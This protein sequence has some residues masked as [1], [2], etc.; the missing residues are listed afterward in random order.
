MK[1]HY[2]CNTWTISMLKWHHIALP[3]IRWLC[4]NNF[5][6]EK[7]T[8]RRLFN[9]E[10]WHVFVKIYGFWF[11][12]KG[13]R[14]TRMST[15]TL[16]RQH[17]HQHYSTSDFHPRRSKQFPKWKSTIQQWW[18]LDSPSCSDSHRIQLYAINWI[19][20]SITKW[21]VCCAC[22]PQPLWCILVYH[23]TTLCFTILCLGTLWGLLLE[24][25]QKNHF[26]FHDVNGD[27]KFIWTIGN[28]RDKKEFRIDSLLRER[29][30][31]A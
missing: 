1:N 25:W 28:E 21:I 8:L 17:K 18:W 30:P 20:L 13:L 29:L 10:M 31:K 9:H 23:Q 6:N 15:V 12:I 11:A 2:A 19:K 16:C 22:T 5:G 7:Q 24:F 26:F 4:S 3:D 27:R 14:L